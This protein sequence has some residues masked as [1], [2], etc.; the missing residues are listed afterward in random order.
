MDRTLTK[1]E[2]KEFA[3]IILS[4][5]P[6]AEAVR[7][8]VDEAVSEE[9]LLEYEE[10][11]PSQPAV[12]GALQQMTGGAPWNEMTDDQRL[13][14]SLTKH[15]NEMAYFLWTTNYAEI[16]GSEKMK[17]DTCR[18]SIEAKVAGMAGRESPLAQFYHDLLTRYDQEG[19]AVN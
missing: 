18:Q 19:K 14:V 10:A 13:D 11:W 1:R 4:G 2:A 8:F 7:Y 17:A 16:G 3:S 6:V 5:A 15:Y 9:R 12:M